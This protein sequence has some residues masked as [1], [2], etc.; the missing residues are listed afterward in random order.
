[1][2]PIHY[3]AE[4]MDTNSSRNGHNNGSRNGH[5]AKTDRQPHGSIEDD[6]KADGEAAAEAD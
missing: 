4:D 1:M 2:L 5:R 3:E 6:G